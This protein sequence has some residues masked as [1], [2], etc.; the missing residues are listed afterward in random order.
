MLLHYRHGLGLLFP[1]ISALTAGTCNV[2][3]VRN[4][5]SILF[6]QDQRHTQQTCSSYYSD[7][8]HVGGQCLVVV[9][10]VW[11][12][13][14]T[15]IRKLNWNQAIHVWNQAIYVWN[16]AINVWY[17]IIHV[18]IH[19]YEYRYFNAKIIWTALIQKSY[20]TPTSKGSLSHI[21][22]SAKTVDKFSRDM[23]QPKISL[24]LSLPPHVC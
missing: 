2:V 15:V 8:Y 6:G 10:S 22:K 16:Q 4:E 18:Q 7:V 24:V 20:K 1:F 23:Q 9:G 21:H 5:L 11:N 3:R 14:D 13:V 12:Q 19:S 17:H